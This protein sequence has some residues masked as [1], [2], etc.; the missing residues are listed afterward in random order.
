MGLFWIVSGS[1]DVAV[2]QIQVLI[3]NR[4]DFRKDIS[5]EF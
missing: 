2:K 4:E 5:V 1:D 3:G